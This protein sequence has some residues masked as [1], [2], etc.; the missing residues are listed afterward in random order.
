MRWRQEDSST[1]HFNMVYWKLKSKMDPFRTNDVTIHSY[2]RIP[3][4]QTYF[5]FISHF[6]VVILHHL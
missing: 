1:A 6:I 2:T 5:L 3:L 4:T